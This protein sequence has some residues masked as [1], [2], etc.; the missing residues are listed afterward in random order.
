MMLLL[1]AGAIAQDSA[2]IDLQNQVEQQLLPTG[3]VSTFV[4][5]YSNAV[6][7][8]WWQPRAELLKQQSTAQQVQKGDFGEWDIYTPRLSEELTLLNSGQLWWRRAY[9]FNGLAHDCG[10]ITNRDL[11]ETVAARCKAEAILSD[12][13]SNAY[14]VV[15]A[16]EGPSGVTGEQYF[17]PNDDR[18]KE[19]VN[20]LKIGNQMSQQEAGVVRETRDGSR[21]PQP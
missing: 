11:L 21:A 19:L 20:S 8:I 6:L 2:L 1:G 15:V 10:M 17:L 16:R 14:R 12:I 7:Q 3:T 9:G 4:R 13:P 5:P 18:L